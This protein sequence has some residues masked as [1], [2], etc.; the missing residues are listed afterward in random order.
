MP[1]PP[2]ELYRTYASWW[3]VVDGG[4]AYLG[5]A[6]QDHL[7]VAIAVNKRFPGRTTTLVYPKETNP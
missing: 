7:E 1:L 4:L 2:V 5:D 3:A 6:D